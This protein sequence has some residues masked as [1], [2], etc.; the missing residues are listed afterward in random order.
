MKRNSKTEILTWSD[1]IP[2][3]VFLKQRNIRRHFLPEHTEA[4]DLLHVSHSSPSA[5]IV[6][7]IDILALCSACVHAYPD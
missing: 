7:I 1:F 6:S 4:N 5:L 2:A 3:D